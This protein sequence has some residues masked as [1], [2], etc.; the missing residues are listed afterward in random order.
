MSQRKLLVKLNDFESMNSLMDP[1]CHGNSKLKN[2]FQIEKK[3]TLAI[4]FNFTTSTLLFRLKAQMDKG[5]Q[6][7]VFLLHILFLF[8]YYYL[9]FSYVIMGVSFRN[10]KICVQ[11]I[12]CTWVP[13]YNKRQTSR[14]AINMKHQFIVS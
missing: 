2:I 1:F 7:I 5:E 11:K 4:H 9:F 8:Y 3:I 12:I 13:L 14:R 10:Y 6:N